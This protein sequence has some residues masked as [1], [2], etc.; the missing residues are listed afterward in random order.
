[1]V[2][3]ISS[4]CRCLSLLRSGVAVGR[5]VAVGRKVAV[6]L[7][8]VGTGVSVGLSVEV[9]VEVAVGVA[10]GAALQALVTKSMATKIN[11]QFFTFTMSSFGQ[12]K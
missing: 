6:G 2:L 11:A 10:G 4:S 12:G 9:G 5:R 8:R 1:M 3:K 7:G